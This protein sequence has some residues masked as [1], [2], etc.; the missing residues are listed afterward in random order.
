MSVDI[1]NT[2]NNNYFIYYEAYGTAVKQSI[3]PNA[4]YYVIVDSYTAQYKSN[5][6]TVIATYDPTVFARDL[7][8][9]YIRKGGLNK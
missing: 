6:L 7:L 1:F 4:T 8:A 5:K 9:E 2:S 3:D